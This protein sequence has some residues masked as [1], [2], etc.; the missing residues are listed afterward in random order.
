MQGDWGGM[1]PKDGFAVIDTFL[2]TNKLKLADEDEKKWAAMKADGKGDLWA[3]MQLPNWVKVDLRCHFNNG[4]VEPEII[5]EGDPE[6]VE[7]LPLP[8]GGVELPIVARAFA[9]D[10][11]TV[12]D[13]VVFFDTATGKERGRVAQ[14]SEAWRAG[15]VAYARDGKQLAVGAVGGNLHFIS[16]GDYSIAR[17]LAAADLPGGKGV[18]VI[19]FAADGKTLYIRAGGLA[20]GISA[21]NGKKG[22]EFAKPPFEAGD[23][24]LSHD[25][26]TL[27]MTSGMMGKQVAVFSTADGK[28]V[29]VLEPK[30]LPGGADMFALCEA[31][32]VQFTPDDG[33]LVAS[34][35]MG[36]MAAVWSLQAG[37]V[38]GLLTTMTSQ[39]VALSPDGR[40]CV[41][42]TWHTMFTPNAVYLCDAA[43]GAVVGVARPLSGVFASSEFSQDGQYVVANRNDGARCLLFKTTALAGA[44]PGGLVVPAGTR[45]ATRP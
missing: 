9:P 29:R 45:A 12:T 24:T 37:E 1:A 26:R 11:K 8:A 7:T 17:T 44:K 30:K 42:A 16:A 38:T 15:S 25:G 28:L 2:T 3:T 39:N 10:S 34:G 13:G 21:E 6:G 36:R 4:K 41:A 22:V 35:F 19:G 23:M 32:H 5:V 27:A 33:R 14:G 18:G 43:S 31:R 20:F 40:F